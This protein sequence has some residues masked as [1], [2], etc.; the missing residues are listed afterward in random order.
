M[1]QIEAQKAF[2]KQ[3]GKDDDEE[4]DVI[5]VESSPN[6]PLKQQ[7]FLPMSQGKAIVVAGTNTLDSS[8]VHL[9]LEEFI[10]MD[11]LPFAFSEKPGFR[12]FLSRIIPGYVPPNRKRVA[13]DIEGP[14][15]DRMEFTIKKILAS[16]IAKD[17]HFSSTTDIWT[18]SSQTLAYMAVTLHWIDDS[19]EMNSL[20]IGFEQIIGLHDGESIAN[21]F[22][23]VLHIYNLQNSILSV[24]LDNAS[25]NATFIAFF[26]V[27]NSEGIICGGEFLHTRCAGHILNL[28]VKDGLA[29]VSKDIKNLRELVKSLRTPQRLEKFKTRVSTHLVPK[30]ADYK[31]LARPKLDVI[32][33]WNSTVDMISSC[34]PYS[35]LFDIMGEENITVECLDKKTGQIQINKK[36]GLPKVKNK[37]VKLSEQG[38]HRLQMLE[39]FLMPLKEATVW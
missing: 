32:T 9:A 12:L 27:L 39:K 11:E 13:K 6:G 26:R 28:M 20:L 10:I 15:F 31:D 5:P 19:W 37:K 29:C 14:I 22:L 1:L 2:A 33:R 25:N 35:T 17:T 4:E 8:Q 7:V 30:N 38:W 34:L 18:C 3:S 21:Q 16:L 24:T 36:T 23:G